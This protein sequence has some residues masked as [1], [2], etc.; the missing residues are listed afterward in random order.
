MDPKLIRELRLSGLLFQ[1][2]MICKRKLW[3]FSKGIR[4]AQYSD[5]VMI[6]RELS[7]SALS[8]K[9]AEIKLNESV[10]VD[11]IDTKNRTI[12]EIKKSSAASSAHILQVQYYLYY[13]EQLGLS[14]FRGVITYPTEFKRLKVESL[15]DTEKEKMAAIQTD[16]HNICN[17][18]TPPAVIRTPYCSGCSHYE[19]CF[20]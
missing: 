15:S 19:F 7:K 2:Y 8:S 4:Y 5:H 16:I 6:G 13:L 11:R 17:Q 18:N 12:Y 3:L 14:G 20:S 9:K 10:V 1:Y